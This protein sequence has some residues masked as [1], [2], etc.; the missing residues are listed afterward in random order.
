MTK[1]IMYNQP[2]L[3]KHNIEKIIMVLHVICMNQELKG[4]VSQSTE[5]DMGLTSH[6]RACNLESISLGSVIF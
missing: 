6:V 5:N 1:N 3:H 2:L 4:F